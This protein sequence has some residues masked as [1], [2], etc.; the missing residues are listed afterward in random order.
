MKTYHLRK[1]NGFWQLKQAGNH[2]AQIKWET[3]KEAVAA[4]AEFCR[5]NATRELP[6][7]LRIAR[8]DGEFTEERTYPYWADP[9]KSKG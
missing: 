2:P 1:V 9:K 7:S 5:E 8:T 4:A 3:K 6:I